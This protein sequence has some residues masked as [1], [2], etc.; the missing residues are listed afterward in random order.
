MKDLKVDRRTISDWGKCQAIVLVYPY[1]VKDRA[2]LIPFYDKFL[3]YIPEDIKII[4]LVKDSSIAD[5]YKK[6]CLA[7]GVLNTI[8]FVEFPDLSDIWVRDYAPLTVSEMGMMYP[9]KF[10]YDPSYIPGKFKHYVELNDKVGSLV[11]KRFIN[12]GEHSLYFVWDMGNLT[13]NGKGT[14]II[15]NRLISDNEAVNVE[16]ELRSMLHVFCGFSKIIF[17]PVEPGDETGHVDGMVRF[18]DEKVLVVGEYPRYSENHNFMEILAKNLR[19]DL[20]DDYT[21]LRMK[22]DEPEDYESEGI[23]SAVGNHMNFLRIN[24][25]ILF[26]YYG[27]KISEGPLMEF[28]ADLEKNKININVI[29]VD[30]PEIKKLAKK[31]GVLNCIS[32]QVFSNF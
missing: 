8:E 25:L 11:G 5:E 6:N 12:V 27:D 32:W 15:S 22:N 14:A 19:T 26:P 7:N 18:I 21:I 10:K 13:H 29:P 3:K 24:D 31:G 16:H 17:I 1:K 20:G 2:H 9:V 4:L 28:K 23:G 30:I